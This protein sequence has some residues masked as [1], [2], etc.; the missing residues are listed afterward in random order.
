MMARACSFFSGVTTARVLY[1]DVTVNKMIRKTGLAVF[2]LAGFLLA[3]CAHET[4]KPEATEAG[5][6]V[7]VLLPLSGPNA[8]LGHELLAGAQLALSATS[9]AQ[10][11]AVPQMDVRDTAGSGGAAAAAAAAISAGDTLL[12]GPLTAGDT[13]AA[14]PGALSAGVP[15][16]AFTSDISQ[17]HP[18]VWVMGITPEDQVQRLVFLAHQEGRTRFAALLPDNPLGRAMGAGLK[19]ACLEQGLPSPVVVYHI[20]SAASIKMTAHE[21]TAYDSRLAQAQGGAG[22]TAPVQAEPVV[23]DSAGENNSSLPADLAAALRPDAEATTAEQK[24]QLPAPPFD[25]LLLGDTGAGL[26]M[27]IDALN[28]TQ[29]AAPSVRIL[30]PG[31]WSAFATKLGAL[32]GAWYAAPDPASRQG[33]V[34]QFMAR[35][36]HMPR[37]L[38][39]LSYDAANIAKTVS[40][41]AP[42]GYPVNILTRSEGFNGVDGPITLLPNGRTRRDLG[43][44]EVIGNGSP[45]KLIAPSAVKTGISG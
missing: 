6:K 42:S 10:G 33:F 37:P 44:F 1:R 12:L 19:A 18:G 38:A 28:E 4:T 17:A 45:A 35:N 29:V 24:L 32:R 26:R 25:A 41:I 43:V 7:G 30:G 20:A 31:L 3:G 9:S 34:N 40:Q 21:L 27:V 16:L 36:H 14:A 2:G 5:H 23:T 22:E 15:V 39:D 8:S 11:V 13:A